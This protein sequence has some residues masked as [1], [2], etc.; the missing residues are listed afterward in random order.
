MAIFQTINHG[1]DAVTA[2][3]TS[4]QLNGGTSIEIPNGSAVAVRANSDNTG[5]IYV[6]GTD[7]SASND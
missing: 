3:G 7:V 5:S 2:A 1:Q 6:G 4:E